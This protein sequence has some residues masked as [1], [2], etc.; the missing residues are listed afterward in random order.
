MN[1]VDLRNMTH[2]AAAKTLKA[3]GMVVELLLEYRPQEYTTF[4]Q[5]VE[6]FKEPTT[7]TSPGI[8]TT[9]KRSFYIRCVRM[10]HTHNCTLSQAS[11]LVDTLQWTDWV[12]CAEMMCVMKQTYS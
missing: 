2:E 3:S 6:N 1:G 12:W 5:E 11:A 8:V 4:Q 10:T 7:P 9:E